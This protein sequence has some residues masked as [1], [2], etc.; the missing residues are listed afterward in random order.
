MSA[1]DSS[2]SGG[3]AKG[4]AQLKAKIQKVQDACFE[5]ANMTV[6]KANFEQGKSLKNN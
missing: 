1:Q 3:G 2:F 6:S 4:T 5:Q